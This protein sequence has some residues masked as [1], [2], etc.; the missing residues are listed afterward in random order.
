VSASKPAP[1]ASPTEAGFARFERTIETQLVPRLL[2][3]HRVGPIP[4]AVGFQAGRV[5]G[6][7]QVTEFCAL[8]RGREADE[9]SAFVEALLDDGITPEVI[10][11]DLLAP[12][13]RMLGT[14][15]EEDTCDFVEV[16]VALGR[17]QSS[18]RGLTHLFL[19]AA[20]DRPA[21]GRVMLGCLPGEQHTL[22]LLIV[23]EFFVRAGWEVRLGAP[24]Q[25]GEAPPSVREEP[26]DVIG[27]SVGCDSRLPAMKRH[28]AEVRRISRNRKIRVL[29]GGRLFDDHPELVARVGADASAS[30][31][32][33][34]PIVAR[35][36][37][38]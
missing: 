34:A 17:M 15:W 18:L 8:L 19:A 37:L 20:D 38:D 2:V 12:A 14:Y 21:V 16:T 3:A 29:V 27:F 11:L 28:I 1:T 9:S 36:L 6:E 13:A 5:M 33:D 7:E 4:P 26:F 23:A 30:D 22:G 31:A 10:Y 32:R 25:A 24:L 35:S